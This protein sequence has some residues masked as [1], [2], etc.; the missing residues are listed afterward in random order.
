MPHFV[1]KAWRRFRASPIW[2]QVV[3]TVFAG[4]LLVSSV[5]LYQDEDEKITA[6]ETTT[7]EAAETSTTMRTTTTAT[8]S[9]TIE[10]TGF[11]A[12]REAW[13]DHH[14][15]APGFTPG[16]A[17]KPIVGNGQP[18]YAAVCCDDFIIS[19]TLN[20]PYESSMELTERRVRDEFAHDATAGELVDRGEC[21]MQEWRSPSIEAEALDGE[22]VPIVAYFPP[23]PTYPPGEQRWSAIFTIATPGEVSDC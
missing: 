8:R 16:S 12:T 3:V 11:G 14:E 7:T 23:D 18:Q 4:L 9:A 13:D 15:R 2:V 21:T 19:Y 5:L 22:Y 17:Y 10:I 1:I 20:M 6:D